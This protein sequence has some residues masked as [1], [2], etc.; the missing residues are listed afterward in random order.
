VT[1]DHEKRG[2]LLAPT[3]VQGMFDRITRRYDLMNRLMTGGRDVAWRR[4][5][6]HIAIGS[7]AE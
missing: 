5:A 7:G 6:A 4:E 1:A 2:A 3:D